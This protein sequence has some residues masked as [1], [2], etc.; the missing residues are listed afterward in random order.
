RWFSQWD[1]GFGLAWELD[2]W[3]RFR[4]AI[5]SADDTLDASVE[6]YDDVLVT[7][8]GDVASSY[9]RIRT[10]QKK[11]GYARQTLDLQRESL[12]IATAKFKGGQTSAV[13]VNQGQSDV[14]ATEDLIEQL[15]IQLRLETNRLCVL[16]GVPPEDL[17]SKLGEAPIPVAPPEVVVGIPADL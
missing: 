15:L 14:S 3:G 12:R 7:L 1:Y 6:N 8:V 5:E 11:I 16:L 4:R 17:L 9:V 2:F 10:L 13:D